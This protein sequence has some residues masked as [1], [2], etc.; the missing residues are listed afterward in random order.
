ME[1]MREVMGWE[2]DEWAVENEHKMTVLEWVKFWG[3]PVFPGGL[4]A[5]D[6]EDLN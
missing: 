1:Y 4:W 2:N 3:E 6:E 5:Q